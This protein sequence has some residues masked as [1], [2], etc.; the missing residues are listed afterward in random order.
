MLPSSKSE[1]TTDFR[2]PDTVIPNEYFIHLNPHL[3]PNNFTFTG[4]VIINA[5][6]VK[7]T[8]EIILH[9]DELQIV[10]ISVSSIDKQNILPTLLHIKSVTSNKKYEFLN[11][12]MKS[13]I[14]SG[15]NIRI[16]ISYKGILNTDQSGFYR[17]WYKINNETRYVISL[18][19]AD[20]IYHTD[21]FIKKTAAKF[22]SFLV[23]IF[24]VHN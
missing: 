9:M 24:N 22:H 21:C 18:I 7:A 14:S 13:P 4:V 3:K 17:R 8:N 6:V 2:L 23:F 11:V 5:H 12:T 15:K 19:I 1:N 10:N 16:D 20:Y